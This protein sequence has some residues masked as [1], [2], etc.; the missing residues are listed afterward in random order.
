M[1]P[2]Y[3]AWRGLCLLK[4]GQVGHIGGPVTVDYQFARV[5]NGDGSI[6]ATRRDLGNLEK[7]ISDLLGPRDKGGLGVIDDDS[8]IQDMR[9]RWG[10]DAP[11]VIT[12]TAWRGE[13]D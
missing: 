7:A 9:L 13:M 1:T 12:V 11:V 8:L 5:R 6:N 10:G 3:S 2:R 4:V